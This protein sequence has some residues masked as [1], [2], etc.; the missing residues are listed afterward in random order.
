MSEQIQDIFSESAGFGTEIFSHSNDVNYNLNGRPFMEDSETSSISNLSEV[1]V[2]WYLFDSSVEKN[3]EKFLQNEDLTDVFTESEFMD[4]MCGK[5][6][7]DNVLLSFIVLK[8]PFSLTIS[9]LAKLNSYAERSGKYIIKSDKDNIAERLQKITISKKEATKDRER[10]TK[11][12]YYKT[13]KEEI[14]KRKK[15]YRETHKEEIAARRKEYRENNLEH[16]REL[17]NKRRHEHPEWDRNRAKKESRKNYMK[18]Y[19]KKYAEEHRE[20]EQKRKKAWYKSNKEKL[21][22]QQQAYDQKKRQ[23]IE[24]AKKVC[25]VHVFLLNLRRTKKPEFLKLYTAQTNPLIGMI[26]TCPALQNMD[27]NMC[28]LCNEN[29]EHSL[30][31]C[32]NQKVLAIPNV[33]Q[34][35]H[36]IAEQLKQR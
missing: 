13:H 19:R 1:F 9:K 23:Q 6:C 28:P 20:A 22:E 18:A 12:I 35:L 24:S 36:A 26:K 16:V 10:A 4:L 29:C 8:L 15:L 30:E 3:I 2:E 27:I 7:L 5:A 17:T 32:C 33:L 34:E 11:K 25:A 14:R 31:Q 21:L